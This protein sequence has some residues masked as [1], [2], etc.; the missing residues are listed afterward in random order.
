MTLSRRGNVEPN[1]RISWIS[2]VSPQTL[3]NDNHF[4]M[5]LMMMLMMLNIY[6]NLPTNKKIHLVSTVRHSRDRR[7]ARGRPK[8]EI[9]VFSFSYFG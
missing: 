6:L 5:M 3:S 1:L 8:V 9:C 4:L 7:K 2:T